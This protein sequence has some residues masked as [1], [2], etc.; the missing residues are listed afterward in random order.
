LFE[1]RA[2]YRSSALKCETPAGARSS[3][4]L[5]RDAVSVSVQRRAE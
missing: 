1:G 5:E 3:R 2:A 4:R